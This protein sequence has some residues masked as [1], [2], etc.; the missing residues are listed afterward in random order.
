MIFSL[1]RVKMEKSK[2][3][4]WISIVSIICVLFVWL[5]IG[6]AFRKIDGISE[7]WMPIMFWVFSLIFFVLWLILLFFIM[8]KLI[9]SSKWGV[10]SILIV[11]ALLW[12]FFIQSFLINSGNEDLLLRLHR[13]NSKVFLVFLGISIILC[14]VSVIKSHKWDKK[15]S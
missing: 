5:F 3:L 4:K 13:V 7:I 14:V 12:M 11:L 15:F 2:S 1:L 10:I 6:L 9:G 8:K